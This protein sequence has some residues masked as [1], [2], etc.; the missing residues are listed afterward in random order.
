MKTDDLIALLARNAGPAERAV[1]ARRLAPALLLGWALST[2]LALWLLGAQPLAVFQTP[3]PWIKLGYAAALVVAAGVLTARLSR[4]VARL[5][6]P[7]RA[8]LGVALAM[9]ALGAVHLAR[10]PA[11]ER[12]TALLGQTW[13][14]CPWNLV[15]LSLP[16]LAVILWAVRGL[17]PTRLPQAGWACGLL[18]GA[19][20]ATGYAL[21]CPESSATFVAIWY[22]LGIGLTAGLGR[23]LGPRVLRW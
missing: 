6:M 18:A 7:R 17:A 11:G 21:S 13:L 2:G 15:M 8:L 16:A 9:G 3:G 20:G 19:I 4:P 10:T 14:L 5:Q 23:W 1:V 12:A 22:T